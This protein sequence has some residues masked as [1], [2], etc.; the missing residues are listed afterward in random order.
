MP[1]KIIN[2]KY[3]MQSFSSKNTAVCFTATF[4]N[5]FSLKQGHVWKTKKTPTTPHCLLIQL[6]IKG[7]DQSQSLIIHLSINLPLVVLVYRYSDVLLYYYV[8]VSALLNSMVPSK[9]GCPSTG[10]GTSA[11]SWIIWSWATEKFY[12]FIFKK[13]SISLNGVLFWKW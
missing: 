4:F 10:A 13:I 9:Q 1:L 11:E 5:M 6:S 7:T 3:N 8:G 2:W 12:I